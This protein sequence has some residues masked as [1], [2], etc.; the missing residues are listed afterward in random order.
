MSAAASNNEEELH[1]ACDRFMDDPLGFVNW[2]FDWGQG[3]LKDS[4]GPDV[5]QADVLKDIE[6]YCKRIAAGENPGPLRLAVASGHGIGK[7]AL[8][9]WII[10]WFMST[11]AHPQIVVTANTENQLRGKTW[12]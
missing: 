7:S 6:N 2:V 4:T 10:Q 8:V 12:R 9:A 11:R 5:W 3:E 1:K